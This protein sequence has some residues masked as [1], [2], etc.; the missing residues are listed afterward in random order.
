M[1][2]L[3]YLRTLLGFAFHKNPLLYVCI[4]VSIFSVATEIAAMVGLLPLVSLA[5]GQRAPQDAFIVRAAQ[6]VGIDPTARA[7]LLIFVGLFSLRI[8]TQFASERLNSWLSKRVL[9]PV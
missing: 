5:A 4:G 8:V 2:Q 3:T 1:R 7:L 6:R 9:A